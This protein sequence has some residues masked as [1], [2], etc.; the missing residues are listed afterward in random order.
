M[1]RIFER[2]DC[3]N[4][5]DEVRRIVQLSDSETDDSSNSG[6]EQ[7]QFEQPQTY[8][9]YK[10]QALPQLPRASSESTEVYVVIEEHKNLPEGESWSNSISTG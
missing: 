4:Y 10:P 8:P 5:A 7:S 2:A 6:E 9:D 3:K 1:I